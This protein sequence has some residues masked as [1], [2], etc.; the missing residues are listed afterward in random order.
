V[1]AYA[2]IVL[3]TAR[4]SINYHV[5]AFVP[6]AIIYGIAVSEFVYFG[7]T[8][9]GYVFLYSLIIFSSL[10]YGFRAALVSVALVI[11]TISTRFWLTH[12]QRT[13]ESGEPLLSNA[14]LFSWLSP[15][16]AFL[17]CAAIAMV[18]IT[19]M[20]RQLGN[21]LVDKNQLVE[22]LTRQI[23]NNK[24][25]QQALDA[26]EDQYSAL[27]KRSNDAVFLIDTETGKHLKAIMLPRN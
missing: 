12:Y 23:E 4:Q 27:F 24:R 6:L 5:R 11:L 1:L 22:D 15:M 10:L 3:V 18:A 26:S 2:G 16:V 14:V 9:L 13:L 20:L 19:M 25:T 21:S 8:A 7:A 17:C